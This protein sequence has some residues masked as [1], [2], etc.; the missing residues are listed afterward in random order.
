MVELHEVSFTVNGNA[1]VARIE[2]RLNLA[3]FL[4]QH[5]GLTGTHVGCEHGVCG[6]CTILIDGRTTRGCLVFAVQASGSEI[7]TIEGLTQRN[8][9]V[10]LQKSL[11]QEMPCN[12]D[13]CTLAF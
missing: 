12:A 4:R 13:F 2:A 11:W 3:D 8:A 10:D 7:E 1:T 9:I 6:A 5:L